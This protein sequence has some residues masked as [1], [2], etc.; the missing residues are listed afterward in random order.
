MKKTHKTKHREKETFKIERNKQPMERQTENDESLRWNG[1]V[2]NK[3]DRGRRSEKHG[4]ITKG[5][6]R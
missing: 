3:I 6:E 2:S 1:A 4:E 5:K